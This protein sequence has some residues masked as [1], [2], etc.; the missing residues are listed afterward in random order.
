MQLRE[1]V[2]LNYTDEIKLPVPA[3][4]ASFSHLYSA[5]PQTDR[6]TVSGVF[7]GQHRVLPGLVANQALFRLSYIP[8]ST[9][10]NNLPGLV[11]SV[12]TLTTPIVGDLPVLLTSFKRDLRRGIARGTKSQAPPATNFYE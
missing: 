12:G 5:C 1:R 10:E 2:P 3:P 4:G 11:H 7:A 8:A 6:S 9:S